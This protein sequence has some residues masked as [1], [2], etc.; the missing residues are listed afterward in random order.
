[1]LMLINKTDNALRIDERLRPPLFA[2][3]AFA[4]PRGF[5]AGDEGFL[6]PEPLSWRCVDRT[7]RFHQVCSEG[8]KPVQERQVLSNPGQDLKGF[9]K[10]PKYVVAFH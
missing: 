8:Q 4:G 5:A 3:S 10:Q 1:M 7:G 2:D 6:C 9:I